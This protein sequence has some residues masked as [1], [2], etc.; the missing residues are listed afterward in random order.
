MSSLVQVDKQVATQA[1]DSHILDEVRSLS[2]PLGIPTLVLMQEDFSVCNYRPLDIGRMERALAKSF[3]I[4]F[5]NI[6]ASSQGKAIIKNN[7]IV[8]VSSKLVEFLSDKTVFNASAYRVKSPGFPNFAD[9]YDPEEY[10]QPLASFVIAPRSDMQGNNFLVSLRNSKNYVPELPGSAEQWQYKALWHEIAHGAGAGEPQ[11]DAISSVMCRKSFED[12]SVIKA[13]ADARALNN[14]FHYSDN[15]EVEKYGWGMVEANDYIV[16][17]PDKTINDMS[18]Y[19]IRD[20]RF[21]KFDPL[22]DSVRNVGKLLQNLE[23]EAFK[24]RDLAALAITAQKLYDD[25]NVKGDEKQILNRFL[26]ACERVSIGDAAYD[27]NNRNVHSRSLQSEH[28]D[29]ITFERG[30]HMPGTVPLTLVPE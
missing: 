16:N 12:N 24:N 2:A 11:A 22:S 14:I 29:P 13:N 18:E 9:N 25:P 30:E 10:K 21:Q 20:I 7:A 27:D 6:D 26:L 1:E 15:N 17:L 28:N 23:S 19:Q 3:D 4:S 8:R 5:P